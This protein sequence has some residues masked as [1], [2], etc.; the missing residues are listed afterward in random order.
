M[1]FSYKLKKALQLRTY[2]QSTPV[3]L[4]KAPRTA[5]VQWRKQRVIDMVRSRAARLTPEKLLRGIDKEE[6]Q[7][8]RDKY[9]NLGERPDVFWTKYL[10]VDKWLALNVRY[11]KEYGLIAKPPRRVLDLGCGGGYFLLVCRQLGS[12][13]VGIDLNKDLVLNE[14]IAVFKL[15][16]VVWHI[17]AFVSLPKFPRKFDLITA[18]MICFNFPTNRPAWGVAEWDYFLNDVSSRLTRKGRVILGLN[19]DLVDGTLYDD[20]LKSY[21]ERRGAT[22]NGKRVVFNQVDLLRTKNARQEMKAGAT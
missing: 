19:R 15:K 16:R 17:R 5:F 21:F 13:V 7:R 9:S 3:K 18:F 12:K 10:D 8:I 6:L 2:T 22:V 4:L 20:T 14:M 1:T 11:A